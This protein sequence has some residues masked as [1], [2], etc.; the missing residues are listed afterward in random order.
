ME[1]LS[2]SEVAWQIENST[3]KSLIIAKWMYELC[4][5][6]TRLHSLTVGIF[7]SYK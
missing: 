2:F 4:M 6:T 3:F 5:S 7:S 1:V